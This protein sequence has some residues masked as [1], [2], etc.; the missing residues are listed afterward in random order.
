MRSRPGTTRT[1]RRRGRCRFRPFWRR[2]RGFLGLTVILNLAML[3]LYAAL[4]FLP[5][6]NVLAFAGVN[7]VM[8]LGREYLVAVAQR[9]MTPPEIS[10]IW[11]AYRGP[12]WL[13]GVGVA[14]LLTVP[15]PQ[16]GS[17]RCSAPPGICPYRSKAESAPAAA[18]IA[19]PRE[20]IYSKN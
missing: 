1:C 11:Q 12:I 7:G 15:D 17:R 14:I 13:A 18:K 5:P 4:L 3:P 9:R 6:L 20:L 2:A 8:L 19:R 16:S 10:R